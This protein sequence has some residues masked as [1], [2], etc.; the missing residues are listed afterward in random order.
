MAFSFESYTFFS[1]VDNK[2]FFDFINF[3]VFWLQLVIDNLWLILFYA[4]F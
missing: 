4:R 3:F 1:I 2:N